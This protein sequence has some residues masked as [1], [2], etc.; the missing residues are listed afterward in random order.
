[1]NERSRKVFSGRAHAT[2]MTVFALLISLAVL[3]AN[4]CKSA[5]ERKKEIAQAIDANDANQLKTLLPKEGSG[6]FDAATY[7][8]FLQQAGNDYFARPWKIAPM[9]RWP[10]IAIV[11]QRYRHVAGKPVVATGK[12]SVSLAEEGPGQ[13]TAQTILTTADGTQYQVRI[14]IEETQYV[15]T[16]L[17]GD[18]PNQQFLTDFDAT[19][20]ISGYVVGKFLEADKVELIQGGGAGHG[21]ALP[22]DLGLFSTEDIIES[23]LPKDGNT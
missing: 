15:G 4:G 17:A 11:A 12:L 7:K 6:D 5:A 22:V 2:A 1:M 21:M 9:L 19:Y 10:V 13:F 3:F 20:R 14:S 23:N 8:A 18:W 16:N